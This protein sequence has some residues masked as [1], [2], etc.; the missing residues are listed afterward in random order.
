MPAYRHIV[1]YL[2]CLGLAMLQAGAA[3][4]GAFRVSPVRVSLTPRAKSQ[5]LTL[6]NR[7]AEPL[8]FQVNAFAWKQS[9]RG[10]IQLQP[11]KDI[12]VFPTMLKIS[13]GDRRIIRVGTVASFG[14]VEKNYRIFVTELPPL[15]RSG[16]TVKNAVQVLTRM[17][18]PV[19]LQAARPVVKARIERLAVRKGRVSLNLRNAGTAHFRSR[20]VR[21][22]GRGALGAAGRLIEDRCEGPVGPPV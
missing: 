5:I 15:R 17:G 21:L 3:Q 22:V 8:R 12:I 6:H 11:T 2:V 1:A 16:K 7:S 13:P 20:G 19:F 4:A 14:K 10:A 18:I 9:R